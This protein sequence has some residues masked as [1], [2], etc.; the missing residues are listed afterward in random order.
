MA[1]E[2]RLVMVVMQKGA[3]SMQNEQE[4]DQRVSTADRRLDRMIEIADEIGVP[5]DHVVRHM[6][7]VEE[8][9]FRALSDNPSNLPRYT[10]SSVRP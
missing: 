7:Y 10:Q 5:L 9:V 8:S 4:T 6:A 3:E 2:S 1:A